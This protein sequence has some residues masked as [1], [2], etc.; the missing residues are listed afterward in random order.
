M[1]RK[2]ADQWYTQENRSDDGGNE[3]KLFYRNFMHS[4]YKQ[5]EAAI[6][7]IISNN[8]SATDPDSAIHLII[9]YKNKRTSQLIMKN[10]PRMDSDP[11][12]KHGVVYHIIC[13]EKGCNHSYIGMTTTRLS[14]RLCPPAGGKL[15][16][17][18]QATP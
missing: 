6:R 8:V 1:K 14:K 13:P 12:K 2:A 18:F 16:P 3:I 15:F 5:D 4:N 7:N 11:L 9:Y 10:S 17:T